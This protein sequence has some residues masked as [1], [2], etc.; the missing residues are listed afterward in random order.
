M[1][2]EDQRFAFPVHGDTVS[3][4]KFSPN[5][6]HLCSVGWDGVVR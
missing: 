2:A 1:A 5:D 6:E 4:L 3:R